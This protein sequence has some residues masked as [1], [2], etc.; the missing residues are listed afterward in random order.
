MGLILFDW[1]TDRSFKK[2]IKALLSI[3]CLFDG[4]LTENKSYQ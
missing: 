2:D 4:Y 3:V 1:E